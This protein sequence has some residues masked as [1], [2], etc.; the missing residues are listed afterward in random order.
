MKVLR[1]ILQQGAIRLTVPE[2]YRLAAVDR[3]VPGLT[4]IEF[5]AALKYS[6]SIAVEF[7]SPEAPQVRLRWVAS[8]TAANAVLR[9]S[10]RPLTLKEISARIAKEFGAQAKAWSPASLRRTL[11]KSFFWL[12]PSLFGLQQHIALSAAQRAKMCEDTHQFLKSLNRPM[13][14]ARILATGRFSWAS[15]TNPYELAEIL[16]EGR[17]F[18]E[19]RRLVFSARRK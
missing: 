4:V 19:G 3:R 16:R 8:A 11:T 12:G 13:S 6:R 14:T 1:G 2:A 17:R 9:A 15:K 5:L 18:A 10:D 7:P